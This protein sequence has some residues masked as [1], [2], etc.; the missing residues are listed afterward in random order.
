M[1]KIEISPR[2][3]KDLKTVGKYNNFKDKKLSDYVNTL[4]DGKELPTNARDHKMSKHSPQEY[5]GT[6]NFHLA[7]DICVI[8]RMD[9][10]NIYLLRIG[11]HNDLNLTE[12]FKRNIKNS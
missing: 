5:Q 9:N 4:S 10:D 3:K 12:I 2:F 11:K 8:Y 6:R 7:P 1:K